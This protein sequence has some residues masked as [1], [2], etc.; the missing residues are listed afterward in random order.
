MQRVETGLPA[1][2]APVE[3]ATVGG[4][5]FHTVQIPIRADGSF[6][7]GSIAKQTEL[8]MRNLVAALAGAGLTT[9]DVA[10]VMAFLVDPTDAAEYNAAYRR[11]FEPPYPAR[12]T[13]FV[14]GLAVPGMRI[15]LVV[16]AH[17]PG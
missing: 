8:T 6:E 12:A 15:E 10:Q 13:L 4:N 2:N 5:A 16:Q 3:W 14:A 1:I 17:L 11:Y 9:R 7:I